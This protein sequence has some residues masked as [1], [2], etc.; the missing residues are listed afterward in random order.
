MGYRKTRR[1]IEVSLK[2]HKIYGQDGD[3]PTAHA[4]GKTLDEYLRLVGFTETSDNEEASLVR[5]LQEFG[6]ALI[7]WDLEQEDGTPIPCTREALFHQ[8]D[9]DLALALAQEWVERLGGKVDETSPL[10]ATSPSGETSLV[11]SVPMAPLSDLPLP[12]SVPA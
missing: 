7:S 8:V 11:E 6:D 5:Q 10:D 1:H 3:Y 12:T 2:G 9:N 4:R